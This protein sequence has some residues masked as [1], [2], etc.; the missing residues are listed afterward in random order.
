MLGSDEIDIFQFS[1]HDNKYLSTEEVESF[2]SKLPADELDARS[3]GKFK[4]LV[5]LVFKTFSTEHCIDSFDIPADWGRICAMDYHPRKPCVIVW[6]AVAPDD[7][8]YAHDEL[9]TQGTI[10]QIAEKIKAK[11]KEHGGTV[12]F[13]FIDSISATP[14]RVTG[15]CPQKDFVKAGKLLNHP[16]LFMSSTK[17]WA[18]GKNAIE[19][20]LK[21]INGKAGLYFFKDRCQKL[22]KCMGRYVWADANTK[23][24]AAEKPKKVYDDFPDALRYAIVRRLSY[25]MFLMR[26]YS[27]HGEPQTHNSG[28]YTGYNLG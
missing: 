10:S 5:G 28:N 24:P 19:E 21:I 20:N 18:S 26:D 2:L 25:A 23:G 11:E 22:I 12:R 9:E 27:Q 14:D 1:I 8:Y 17:N 3:E 15:S 16:M 4:H 6:I 7:T 13:R